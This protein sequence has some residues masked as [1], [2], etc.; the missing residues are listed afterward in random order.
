MAIIPI[1]RGSQGNIIDKVMEQIG[2]QPEGAQRAEDI[3]GGICY[4]LSM[5]W[6]R[7]VVTSGINV[8][9]INFNDP[10]NVDNNLEVY[11]QIANNFHSYVQNLN[12]QSGR[13]ADVKLAVEEA[14][15]RH[16]T[17]KT[18]INALFVEMCSGGELKAP[19]TTMETNCD[20]LTQQFNAEKPQYF[21]LGFS[22]KNGG[23]RMAGVRLND[24]RIVF[25]DPNYG[26][27]LIDTIEE[28]L[29]LICAHYQKM[30]VPKLVD[31]CPISFANTN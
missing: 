21:L 25:Y 24:G 18:E 27:S 15:R 3:R 1:G 31:F 8:G 17:S 14:T 16:L 13:A 23:H 2:T 10:T 30:G 22:W 20:A 9:T 11:G 19:I 28:V 29:A 26:V 12:A 6:I 7:R 5:E 4:M